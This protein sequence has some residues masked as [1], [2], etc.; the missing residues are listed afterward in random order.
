MQGVQKTCQS[1]ILEEWGLDV[2]TGLKN[3][4]A[5]LSELGQEMERLSRHGQSFSLALACIDDFAT[6]VNVLG[7]EQAGAL[8]KRVATLVRRSLR[9]FD[10][11][12]NIGGGKFVL[13]LKLAD[14]NGGQKALTRLRDELE[15]ADISFEVGGRRGKLTMSCCVAEPLPNDHLQTLL[16]SLHSDLKSYEREAGTVMTYFEMSPLQQFV[17]SG[18][19]KSEEAGQA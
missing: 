13:S 16:D 11:A 4:R 15:K 14:L 18:T 17:R 7:D 8:V 3:R 6:I 2:L 10:G 19:G 9:S 5:M 12:Y 1:L